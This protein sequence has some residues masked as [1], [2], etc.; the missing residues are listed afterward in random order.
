MINLNE[1]EKHSQTK[2][3]VIKIE[4]DALENS[5]RLK[6]FKV[7][8]AEA[9][10]HRELETLEAR[11]VFLGDGHEDRNEF[12]VYQVIRTLSKCNESDIETFPTSFEKLAITNDWPRYK[13]LAII[14]IQMSQNAVKIFNEFPTNNLGHNRNQTIKDLMNMLSILTL[15]LSDGL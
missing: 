10:H 9:N 1:S 2:K 5:V 4:A 8:S 14:Q 13:Y 11:C 15:C 7:E 12:R 3:E 6:R